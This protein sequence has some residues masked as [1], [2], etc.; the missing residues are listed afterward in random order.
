MTLPCPRFFITATLCF[1]LA[2]PVVPASD[3]AKEQRWREQIVEALLDGEPITLKAGDTEFLGIYTEQTAARAQGAVI[4]LH[5][6]GVHPDWPDVIQ[7]LR[8]A[9]PEYGWSTLSIQMPI[10][11]N[12]AAIRDYAAIWGEAPPRIDAAV[13]WLKKQGIE[14]IALVAHSLGASMATTY[15]AGKPSKNVRALVAIGLSDLDLD[16]AMSSVAHLKKI[17]VPVLDLYGSLDMPLIL[18]TAK[19]RRAAARKAGNRNYVQYRVEGADH[20][21]Q[22]AEDALV[23]KVRSWLARYA[24]GTEIR[25]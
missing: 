18:K 19:L 16:P 8:I 25:R 9:L 20:F 10:L 13:A 22:G 1:L 17:R 7:P 2:S 11:A 15:L 12:D 4:L 21:F 24:A 14:N 6:M 3:T 23:K 5:G